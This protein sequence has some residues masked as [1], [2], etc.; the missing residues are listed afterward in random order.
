MELALAQGIGQGRHLADAGDGSIQFG[1][2]QFEP[3]HQGRSQSLLSSGAQISLIGRQDFRAGRLEGICHGQDRRLALAITAL[4]QGHG[5][6]AH[7]SSALEQGR[8]GVR[9]RHHRRGHLPIIPSRP[10]AQDPAG[11][12]P[13]PTWP[14]RGDLRR[15]RAGNAPAPILP[16]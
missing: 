11:S 5:T 9:N 13:A 1:A 16:G 2:I 3:G 4:A 15:C 10:G 12:G 6:A 8:T 14:H 7:A